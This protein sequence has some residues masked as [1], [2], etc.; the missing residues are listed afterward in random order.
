[1]ASAGLALCA[2]HR[3][4]AARHLAVCERLLKGS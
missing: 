1:M 4:A 3:G 2:A